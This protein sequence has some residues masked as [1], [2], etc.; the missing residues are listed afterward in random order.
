MN[1]KIKINKSLKFDISERPLI[2]AEISG[3]HNGSKKKFLNLIKEA[4][5]AGADL[6]K[7]QTYEPSDITIKS[8]KKKF[9]IKSGLWNKKNLWN[10]YKKAH[11]PFSWHKDAFKLAKKLKTTL[12]SSPFSERAVDLLEKHKVSL[13]KLASLEITDLNLVKKIAKTKKPIII[14][15]G[16]ATLKEIND[17]LKLIKR[18]HRKIIIL[19]CVSDYPT[20]NQNADIQRIN[21]LRKKFKSNFIGLSDHTTDIHSAVAA[22]ALN[23]VVIEKH[24]KI[25]ENSKSVDSVF[26]ISPKKMVQLKEFISKV[27]ESLK[28]KNKKTQKNKHFRRSI[29]ALKTIQK[30]E[31]FTKENIVALRPKLGLCA[32]KYFK[33]LNKRSRKIILKDSPIYEA[34]IK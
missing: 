6:I 9:F 33:I 22:T 27:H 32:S 10:L 11:T 3:N 1:N 24:F 31:K 16:A 18:Y 2:I 14:S 28:S 26:S 5:K 29:Y 34:N 12:F 8:S 15:T 23:V 7:I 4:H 25:S 13:Y 17:C 20:L 30:N 21:F 19:H